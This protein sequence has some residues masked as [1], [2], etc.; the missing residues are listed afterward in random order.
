MAT[1]ANI[2]DPDAGIG[3]DMR[4]ARVYNDSDEEEHN[5]DRQ[6]HPRPYPYKNESSG[7]SCCYF[8]LI[9]IVIVI[10]S[11]IGYSIGSSY[12]I[13]PKQF[14]PE[15][16]PPIKAD[17]NTNN[18]PATPLPTRKD[19]FHNN[20]KKNSKTAA[21]NILI[22]KKT[23][24]PTEVTPKPAKQKTT[25]IKTKAEPSPKPVF[26]PTVKA[27]EP[28]VAT[29]KE[30]FES[31][32]AKKPSENQKNDKKNDV[33]VPANVNG[34]FDLKAVQKILNDKKYDLE[35]KDKAYAM[36]NASDMGKSSILTK[37]VLDGYEIPNIFEHSHRFSVKY[38][39]SKKEY[40][41]N[42]YRS[43]C[44]HFYLF[45]FPMAQIDIKFN[46]FQFERGFDRI[47]IRHFNQSF[48]DPPTV[49][50]GRGKFEEND[51]NKWILP[52]R[53]TYHLRKNEFK[54]ICV[55]MQ[56]DDS[57]NLQGI[58]FDVNV[59]YDNCEWDDLSECFIPDESKKHW[60]RGPFY[61][62]QCGIGVQQRKR[63]N[64]TQ[65]KPSDAFVK[66]S[67][68]AVDGPYYC[69]KAPWFVI[70]IHCMRLSHVCTFCFAP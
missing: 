32:I 11:V 57:V 53:L 23:P 16:E 5:M 67:N 56:S 28:T 33:E 25:P 59:K 66:C 7:C 9:I 61:D 21:T 47:L 4:G 39:L 15:T 50:A 62:G 49:I 65:N 30:S 10:G 26:E 31:F 48:V 52:E 12:S 55:E 63:S 64:K 42:E 44:F 19:P 37:I 22:P 51:A 27:F 2:V 36:N 8:I 43:W 34:A 1:D 70:C 60:D 68:S 20:K 6:S 69:L 18:I 29:K 14:N 45:D 3:F 38:P 40:S 17:T 54:S 13:H 41:S 46:K 35:F 58:K 24:K